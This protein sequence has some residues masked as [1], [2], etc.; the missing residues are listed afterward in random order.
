MLNVSA[1]AISGLSLHWVGNKS[2]EENIHKGMTAHRDFGEAAE[3]SFLHFFLTPFKAAAEFYSFYHPTDLKFNEV[4]SHAGDFLDRQ[5]SFEAFSDNMAA[6]LYEY[7]EHPNISGG[8]LFVVQFEGI[9]FNGEAVEALGLYKSES[10]DTFIKT[11]QEAAG[12]SYQFDSGINI[13]KIDKACL[14]LRETP[15]HD[16]TVCVLDKSRDTRYWMDDFLKLTTRRDD[17]HFTKDYLDV[18]KKFVTE[19]MPELYEVSKT[20][21][22]DYL[23]KSIN[24]FREKDQFAKEEFLSDV[25]R[26]EE[27]IDTFN[28]FREDYTREYGLDLPEDSFD[29]SSQAVKKQSRVFKSVLKLDKNF[30]VYIHGDKSLIEQGVESDGRKFYKIYYRE[31]N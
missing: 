23:N 16:F 15:E 30:H 14:I 1:A 29:I 21:C 9:T 25:F 2:R 13:N 28:R 8:E 17:F 19:K 12:L 18:T 5:L 7:S 22:I 11:W 10:R 4:R 6:T 27:V 31:E 24:Y 3:N 20:D 26:H